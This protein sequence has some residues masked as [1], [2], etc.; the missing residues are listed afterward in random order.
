MTTTRDLKTTLI[1]GDTL[2]PRELFP[3]NSSAAAGS[4]GYPQPGLL[5]PSLLI[6]DDETK[7]E[8]AG[9]VELRA[10]ARSSA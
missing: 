7:D 4:S 8:I 1:S 5:L 2:I 10:D 6:L 3:I 9:G